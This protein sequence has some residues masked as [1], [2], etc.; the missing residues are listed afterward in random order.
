MN[1]IE[2]PLFPLRTVLFPGADLPLRIFEDRYRTMTR[3]LLVSHG[4]FGVLLI[5]EGKEVGGSA[6]PHSVGT[7]ASIEECREIEGGRF[8]MNARGVR[9]FTTD[10][11][12]VVRGDAI[13]IERLVDVLA[14]HSIAPRIQEA[15]SF[16][17]ANLVLL[18]R[19][20]P[21]GVDL[22]VSLAWSAFEHAALVN[23][24]T[25]AFGRAHAP[26]ASAEDLVVLKAIAGRPRD[27]A[28]V[29]SLSTMFDA[30]IARVRD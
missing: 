15:V 16:A 25:E 12:V 3:E 9:R 28:D 29:E 7:T 20:T 18:M 5:R 27:A 13:V 19:H 11:D 21:T 10:I 6:L 22:D 24:S 1:T 26:M 23:S 30:L 14:E 2:I 8:V 17:R 4:Q